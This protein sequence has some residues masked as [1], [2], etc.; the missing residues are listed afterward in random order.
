MFWFELNG[1][2][3]SHGLGYWDRSARQ[4]GVFRRMIDQDPEAFVQLVEAMPHRERSRLWGDAY[5]RPKG[6]YGPV[7]DP[8]YNRKQASIGYEDYFGQELFSD[9]LPE[10]L[11]KSFSGLMPLYHY[12]METAGLELKE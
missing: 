4:A 10:L 3:T 8:W 2:G 11:S 12:M 7:I 1:E 6:S 9:K 5:K